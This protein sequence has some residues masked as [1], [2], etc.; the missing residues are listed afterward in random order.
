MLWA[1]DSDDV[2]FVLNNHLQEYKIKLDR[3]KGILDTKLLSNREIFDYNLGRVWNCSL[4]EA[5]KVVDGFF[6]SEYFDRM[7]P[8]SGAQ[9]AVARIRDK[10]DD[11]VVLTSRPLWM[12]QKT[13]EQISNHYS[14]IFN[15]VLFSG[16]W[17]K[18][19]GGTPKGEIC[20]E[21][22]AQRLVDDRFKYVNGAAGLVERTYLFDLNGSYGWNQK[23]GDPLPSHITRVKSWE[24]ILK[25][26]NI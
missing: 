23:N 4:D 9:E 17:S 8:V 3:E 5:F 6:N 7:Q 24:E 22:G 25:E 21:I 19:P 13:L 15:G 1:I 10:G 2:L 14:G 18:S 26:E 11:L 20:R 16:E 12:Q